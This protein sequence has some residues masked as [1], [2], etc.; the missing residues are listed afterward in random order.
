MSKKHVDEMSNHKSHEKGCV[1]KCDTTYRKK[2]PANNLAHS[3]RY[4]G[5]QEIKG[6]LAKSRIYNLN[7]TSGAAKQRMDRIGRQFEP[8]IGVKAAMQLPRDPRKSPTA[9][10]LDFGDNFTDANVPY[11]HN[12]H[13]M[14][15][16][17]ALKKVFTTRELKLVQLSTYSL[18]DGINL[19]ILPRAE[20]VGQVLQ[21]PTHTDNHPEYSFEVEQLLT[22][23]KMS[24]Q[25]QSDTHRINADN[26]GS[27]KTDLETIEDMCWDKIVGWGKTA[28][29]A[30]FDLRQVN[31]SNF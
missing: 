11:V 29:D 20:K 22:Q 21:L 1:V 30:G 31:M 23:I 13:H 7:F 24:L 4:N 9:W 25:S 10:R 27:L 28:G 15:P 14:V 19:I 12:Y 6:D 26:V 5:H 16:W 18:N 3:Y 8:K 17:D 2:N